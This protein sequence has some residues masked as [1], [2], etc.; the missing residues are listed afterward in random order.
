MIGRPLALVMSFAKHCGMN[1]VLDL[2]RGS[3]VRINPTKVTIISYPLG[4]C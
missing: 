2:P 4:N 3:F 1:K